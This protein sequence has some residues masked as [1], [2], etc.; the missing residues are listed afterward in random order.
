MKMETTTERESTMSKFDEALRKE[1]MDRFED[2]RA[3]IQAALFDEEKMKQMLDEESFNGRFYNP[4]WVITSEARVWSL[5]KNHNHGGF[6]LPKRSRQGRRNQDG[7]YPATRRWYEK[8]IWPEV[9]EKFGTA[10]MVQ[11]YYHQMVAN[12]FCDRTA[13]DIFGES[14][15]VA[16]HIFRYHELLDDG[17]VATRQED[18]T[19][20]NRANHLR[21]V[22]K[23]DHAVL[24]YIQDAHNRNTVDA[25]I[26]KMMSGI[27]C[28]DEE[29]GEEITI[30]FQGSED[31]IRQEYAAILKGGKFYRQIGDDVEDQWTALWYEY[32]NGQNDRRLSVQGFI[33]P[34]GQLPFLR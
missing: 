13:L 12:Y 5:A 31:E 22:T 33:V 16:H 11:L 8:N 17:I 23:Y 1:W 25:A 28:K 7:E 6:L 19:W 9:V 29:T 4:M 2:Q 30:V 15:C 10:S 20:N 21:W 18:C 34:N 24:T 26:K 27:K 3:R 14:H 32:I